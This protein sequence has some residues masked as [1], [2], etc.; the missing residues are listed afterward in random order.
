MSTIWTKLDVEKTASILKTLRKDYGVKTDEQVFV[1]ASKN[2]VT[3][4]TPAQA[5]T[6]Y[7]GYILKGKRELP[8]YVFDECAIAT[9]DSLR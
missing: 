3:D 6:D 2:Q 8:N 5:K 1:R 9:G 7:Q 4:L